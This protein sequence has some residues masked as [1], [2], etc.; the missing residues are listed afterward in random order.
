MPGMMDTILNLGLND[1]TV[2][3]LSHRS[4][5]PRF[6]WDSYRRFVQMYGD[7]VMGVHAQGKDASDPFEEIL[8]AIKKE[9]RVEKD[10]DLTAGN[11]QVLVSR[12]KQLIKRRTGRATWTISHRSAWRPNGCAP[13][14]ACGR[15]TP[16]RA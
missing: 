15:P 16:S 8:G 1:K 5:N 10:T 2:E 12:Y 3:V 11:L 14:T 9:A 7:V 4:G 6:A 13:R